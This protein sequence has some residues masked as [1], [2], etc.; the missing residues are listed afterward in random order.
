M[1]NQIFA[2]S[3]MT[4]LPLTLLSNRP[5]AQSFADLKPA[6]RIAVPTLT[7]PQMYVLEL[8]SE[9]IFGQY[10][11]LRDQVVALSPADAIAALVEGGGQERSG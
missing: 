5:D 6:D 9:K 7:S 11:R 3:G 10:D 4:S 8:Q 1:P 2:V